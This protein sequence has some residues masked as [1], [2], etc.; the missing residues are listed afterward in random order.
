M[1]ERPRPAPRQRNMTANG[2]AKGEAS[3]QRILD[4]AL[5]VFGEIGYRAATT[6]SIAEAA[7][8]KLP[9]LSYYFGGK[10]QLYLA[11]AEEIVARYREHMAPVAPQAE[12]ALTTAAGPEQAREALHLLI[13][14]LVDWLVGSDTPRRW[15]S[16]VAREMAD[17]GPGYDILFKRLWLPGVSLMARLLSQLREVAADD[18]RSRL[19]AILLIASLTAFQS[20]RSVSM[21]ALQWSSIGAE[22]VRMISAL[23]KSQVDHLRPVPAA[24]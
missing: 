19:Q 24:V 15:S 10:E 12:K 16:F 14:A 4:A 7:G 22:E 23:M 18:D 9:A 21:Q 1:T 5:E 6:R 11:C 17:P 3:R 20:G 8:L 2:Y 13:D